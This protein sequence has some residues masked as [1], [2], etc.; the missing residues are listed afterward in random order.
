MMVSSRRLCAV[1]NALIAALLVLALLQLASCAD[2]GI[3]DYL[4]GGPT[5][6]ELRW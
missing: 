2:D 6:I 3:E 1:R 5:H 4:R